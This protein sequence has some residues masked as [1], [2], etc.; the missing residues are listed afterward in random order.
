MCISFRNVFGNIYGRIILTLGIRT[1]E[2][3]KLIPLGG[4]SKV[5]KQGD[6]GQSKETVY[7]GW[8]IY[9]VFIY[10]VI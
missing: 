3:N 2:E 7:M 8:E 1:V 9:R 4:H 6:P 10:V 5:Q